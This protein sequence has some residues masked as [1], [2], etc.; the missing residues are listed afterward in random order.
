MDFTGSK[1]STMGILIPIPT[2]VLMDVDGKLTINNRE[3][4]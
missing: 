1:P 3:W 2:L 4:T